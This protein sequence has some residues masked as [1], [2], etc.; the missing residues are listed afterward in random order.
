MMNE[1]CKKGLELLYTEIYNLL[2]QNTSGLSNAEIANLLELTSSQKGN[3]KNYLTYS[4][5]GNLIDIGKV[6]KIGEGKSSKYIV[7]D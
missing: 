6:I 2:K 7:K 3:Q 1:S 4:L 5:L